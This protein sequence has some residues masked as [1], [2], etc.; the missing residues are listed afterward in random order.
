[1]NPDH[2]DITPL[3]LDCEAYYVPGFLNLAEAEAL[4]TEIVTGF[5]VTNKTTH[6]ADGTTR[7]AET[8]MYFFTNPELTSFEALPEV[9]GERAVWTASLAQVR[10]RIEVLTGIR[11]QVARAVYYQDGSEGC[12]FHRDLPAYGDTST[13]ASL[14]LGAERPFAFRR[15]ADPADQ[16]TMRLAPGSLLFMGKGCQEQYEHALPHDPHCTT[17]RLNLTFRKYGW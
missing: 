5:D 4:Y 16:W 2:K 1:M 6:M 15:T 9:W 8:G 11:F 12:G 7:I 13:I 17:P 14:S 10:D 3:P